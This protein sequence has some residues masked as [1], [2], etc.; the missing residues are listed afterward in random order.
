MC[1]VTPAACIYS[2]DNKTSKRR[3]KMKHVKGLNTIAQYEPFRT[4]KYM[5]RLETNKNKADTMCINLL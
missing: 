5:Y 4:I 1:N 2:D 3:N